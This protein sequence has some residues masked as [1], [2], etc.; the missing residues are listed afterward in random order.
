MTRSNQADLLGYM[1]GALDAPETQQVED[2]IQQ[3]PEL[4]SELENVQAALAPLDHL[5]FEPKIPVGIARRTLEFVASSSRSPSHGLCNAAADIQSL[6]SGVD[7]EAHVQPVPSNAVPSSSVPANSALSDAAAVEVAGG[8]RGWSL[9][10]VLV[11]GVAVAV[12]VAIA[13]PAVSYARFQNRLVACENNLRQVGNALLTYK[14]ISAD[15]SFPQIQPAASGRLDVAGAYAPLLKE[16]NLVEDDQV[17]FCA[18]NAQNFDVDRFIPT[19]EQ[20]ESADAETLAYFRR[21]MGGDFGYSMGYYDEQGN[22]LQP[23]SEGRSHYAVLADKPSITA[24]GHR[25]ANHGGQG[26]N[27][28]FEDGH[29]EFLA[30]PETKVGD[31]IYL[32][33]SGNCAPS[34]CPHDS[35]IGNSS[36]PVRLVDGV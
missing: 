23:R 19:V 11:A 31:A 2:A 15:H 8:Q 34:H 20:I 30:T 24:P 5:H 6:N 12:L 22:Y 7:S 1:L 10:D 21:R 28:W 26:Q 16:K 27:V 35:C 14:D 13:I 36:T 32:N 18:G 17:F 33:D 29:T 9:T 4:E 25:S 3:N